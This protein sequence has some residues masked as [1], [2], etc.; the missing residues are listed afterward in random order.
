MSALR[1][2]YLMRMRVVL[3]RL[4][5]SL[6]PGAMQYRIG[7]VAESAEYFPNTQFLMIS[8]PFSES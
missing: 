7:C 5:L 8:R 6:M 3:G 1:L 2:L 4:P